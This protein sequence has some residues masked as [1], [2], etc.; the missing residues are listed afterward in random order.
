MRIRMATY[1]AG[2]VF[3][4]ALVGMSLAGDAVK[5]GLKPGEPVNPF[6]VED[7]TGPSKGTSLCYRCQYG[8]AA[9]VCVFARKTSDPLASLV[10]QIDKKI[11]ENGALKSF[12]V[13]IP[14]KDEK[15]K[16]SLE[17]LAKNSS[18]KNVPLTIGE[19]PNGPPDY[20]IAQ[21]GDVTVLMWKDGKV[22]VN[23]AYKGELTDK[24]VEAVVADIPK[25]LAD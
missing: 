19:G 20:E 6:T 7:V 5:S 1:V 12:V 15:V 11:A 14:K 8:S 22:R 16:D 10:K 18:I 25:V 4:I 21:E 17:K 13:L 24:D 23:H 3:S 2:A 9:V